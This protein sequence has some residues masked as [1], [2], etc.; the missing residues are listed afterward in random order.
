MLVNKKD[1][2]ITYSYFEKDILVEIIDIFN[3]E[4]PEKVNSLY[5]DLQ[6]MNFESLRFDAHS[7]K[8]TIG[9]FC[10]TEVWALAKDLEVTA[11]Q[12]VENNGQGFSEE[13]IHIKIDKLRETIEIM[14]SELLEIRG[15][16]LKKS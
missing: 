2:Y 13:V 6:A 5:A 11:A 15:E 1:F 3:T 9:S 10:A 4:A 8:G 7:L 14:T 16:L 12:L